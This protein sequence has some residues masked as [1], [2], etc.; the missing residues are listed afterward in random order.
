MPISPGFRIGRILGI[1]I[2]LHSTWFFIFVLITTG[3]GLQ[4]GQIHPKWSEEQQ[5]AVGIAASLL[6]F[7]SVL[8]HEFSHSLVAQHYKIRVVSITLFFFGGLARISR[9]PA[10]AIQEFNIAIAGP[11]ASFFLAGVFA[12]GA[13][14]P[15][16]EMLKAVSGYLATTNF[17]LAAFNLLPGFPLD[18]GRIFRAAIWGITKDFSRATKVAGDSGRLVAY[19][20]IAVG[21]YFAFQK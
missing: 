6:F 19:G 9:E 7:A 5:W 15:Q 16:N 13:Q 18:G 12:L 8:F 1:P 17:W 10:K 3:L 14:V 4:F 20:I 2:Y 21:A 11:L